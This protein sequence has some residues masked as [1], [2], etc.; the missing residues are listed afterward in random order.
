MPFIEAKHPGW[1]S[2]LNRVPH[3][4]YHLPGYGSIEAWLLEGDALAW[5]HE[6]AF[7]TLLIPLIA[8][9]IQEYPAYRDLVSPYGYPGVLSLNPLSSEEAH[10]FLLRFNSEAKQE[11]YVSS[12]IRLNP[13][14]NAW[15]LPEQ[16]N[17]QQWKHGGTVSVPLSLAEESLEE[18]F[19]LNHRR[20][21]KKL[22]ELGYHTEI[23]H[24]ESIQ[25]FIDAYRRTMNRRSAHSYYFFP[26]E[27][28]KIITELLKDKLIYISVLDAKRNWVAG[29]LF[30][31]FNGTMQYHLGA[32]T[33]EAY[34]V[35]PSKLMIEA[36]VRIGKERGASILHLGGGVGGST[37]DGLFRFK[38]GFG[39]SFH[40]FSTLRF[41]HDEQLY[42]DLVSH[43]PE[44]KRSNL[45]FPAYRQ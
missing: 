4:V 30:T 24:Y 2:F 13:V 39:S 34:F 35:S 8:R 29:G 45:Y 42:I 28:F 19:S 20:N 12:F 44:Q 37:E 3:D 21:L 38:K 27:Y 9:K 23:N 32:T 41:I 11:S 40:P 15:E 14:L 10:E 17:Y 36:A 31:L 22:H 43:L 5:Y 6:D 25:L 33:D 18:M 26:D 7:N 16:S 1:K